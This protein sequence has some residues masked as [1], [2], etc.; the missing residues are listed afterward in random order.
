METKNK[1]AK[2]L[3]D[4]TAT[5]INTSCY[6]YKKVFA[7]ETTEL[8]ETGRER[9]GA[10][11]C[12][13]E[14]WYDF[15]DFYRQDDIMFQKG[16]HRLKSLHFFSGLVSMY[17]SED[18]VSYLHNYIAMMIRKDITAPDFFLDEVWGTK[19]NIEN[20]TRFYFSSVNCFVMEGTNTHESNIF[21]EGFLS[22][23]WSIVVDNS[24]I[25]IDQSPHYIEEAALINYKAPRLP[26]NSNLKACN[27]KIVKDDIYSLHFFIRCLESYK[28]KDGVEYTDCVEI[29]FKNAGGDEIFKKTYANKLSHFWENIRE[30]IKLEAG[31]YNIE[32]RAIKSLDLDFF[33]LFPAVDFPSVTILIGSGEAKSGRTLFFAPGEADKVKDENGRLVF[34]PEIKEGDHHKYKFWMSYDDD[35]VK[36]AKDER[37]RM[38][39]TLNEECWGYW[40]ANG[41]F[42]SLTGYNYLLNI[43]MPVGVS[44]FGVE[45]AKKI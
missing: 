20:A 32:I 40:S 23:I 43:L 30:Y 9:G 41:G 34:T 42:I 25:S 36:D 10:I 16:L 37:E 14:E 29:I 24:S 6:V 1:V 15:L 35:T 33:C 44:V 38:G 31:D 5:A 12:A 21:K 18:M 4:Y 8:V 28:K 17:E 13:I 3:K 7:E 2:R 11:E 22:S 27:V 39:I 26:R 19:W 45:L